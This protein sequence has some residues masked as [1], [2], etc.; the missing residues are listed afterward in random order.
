M[1]TSINR[2]VIDPKIEQIVQILTNLPPAKVADVRDYVLFLG[3]RYG[4]PGVVDDSDAWT[5]DDMADVGAASMNYAL[6]SVWRDA[7]NG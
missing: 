4:L 2:K 5:E 1:T 3:N 7:E 6:Q